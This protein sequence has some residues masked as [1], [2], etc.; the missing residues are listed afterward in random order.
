MTKFKRE[1]KLHKTLNK[2]EQYFSKTYKKC[3]YSK[4]YTYIYI[5]MCVCV[6]VCVCVIMVTICILNS[7]I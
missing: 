7:C 1:F 6:C 2:G 5:Y 3:G 4:L